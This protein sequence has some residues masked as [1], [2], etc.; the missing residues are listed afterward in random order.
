MKIRLYRFN[1]KK[2]AFFPVFLLFFQVLHCTDYFEEGKKL[3]TEDKPDEAVTAF[4]AATKE[5]EVPPSINLYLGVS[6]LRLGKYNEAISY[7]ALGRKTDS[8]NSYLYSYNMGNI[9]FLQSR[10][11][12][13]EQAYNDAIAANGLYAPAFLN[14][15]N[16]RIRLDK[17]EGALQDYKIY[18]NLEPDTLQKDSI[19]RLISLLESTAEE[20][21]KVK[22]FTEAKAAAEEAERAAADERYKQLIDEVSA[23]LTSVGDADALSAGAEDT[24]DYMEEDELE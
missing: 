23:S 5:T 13:C 20:K 19:E 6:Y 10:F 4:F 7:L 21:A 8:P 18:L 24:L 15:A 17:Y 9:Y 2:A 1:I 22:A 3:L 14:R 11:D 12:A 16:A